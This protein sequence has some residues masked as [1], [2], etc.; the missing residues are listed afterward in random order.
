MML[1]AI[2]LLAFAS[3]AV[4]LW[5]ASRGDG[6]DSTAIEVCRGSYA[7]ARNARDSTIIDVQVPVTSRGQ[8]SVA[9]SCGVLRSAGRLR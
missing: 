2:G 3:I 5:H 6:P 8:A 1:T 9:I 7:R 4:Y